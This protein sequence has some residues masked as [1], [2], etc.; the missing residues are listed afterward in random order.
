MLNSLLIIDNEGS[1]ETDS[2]IVKD[3]ILGGD[4]FIDVCNKW[5]IDFTQTSLFSWFFSPFHMTEVGINRA[6]NNLAVD[7][8]ELLGFLGEINNLSWTD[9]GKVERIEKE[10]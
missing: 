4:F 8:S 6:T 2:T 5:D 7:I 1:S 3:S 9:K 10:K